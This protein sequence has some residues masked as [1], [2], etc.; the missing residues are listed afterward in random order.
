[1]PV[2]VLLTMNHLKKNMIWVPE[3]IPAASND[4]EHAESL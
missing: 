4:T 1:M 3:L 2:L